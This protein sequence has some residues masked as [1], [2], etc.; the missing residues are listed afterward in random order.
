M[1][2]SEL[3]NLSFGTYVLTR[4][5]EHNWTVREFIHQ[6]AQQGYKTVSPAYIS[7]IEQGDEI[8]APELILNIAE[9]FRDNPH[10]LLERAKRAKLQELK[11]ALEAKYQRAIITLRDKVQEG[12]RR[13]GS[14]P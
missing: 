7:R 4:R 10:M 6:L 2:K 1:T 12:K 8:P 5:K 3:G 9:V 14:K 11:N 13:Y